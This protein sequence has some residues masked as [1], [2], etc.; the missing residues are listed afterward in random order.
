MTAVHIYAPRPVETACV[1]HDCPTCQRQRRMIASYY[2]WHGASVGCAGCG[3][4]WHDG[5]QQERPF[6]QGWRRRSIERIRNQL[7][8]IGVQA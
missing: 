5:E 3:E 8:A 7:A 2:E 4:W 6:A 1:V